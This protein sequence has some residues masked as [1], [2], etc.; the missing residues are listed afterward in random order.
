V[1]FCL[2]HGTHLDAPAHCIP[3]G[4]TIDAYP[5]ARFHLPASVVDCAGR[6]GIGTDYL[7]S[8]AVSPGE[9]V[10][11][12]SAF[13]VKPDFDPNF[14]Y[15]DEAVAGW[16]VEQG[17]TLVGIDSPSIERFGDLSLSVHHILLGNDILILEQLALEPVPPGRYLLSCPPLAFPGAEAGPCR[18]LLSPC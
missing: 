7:A 9:A 16:L 4:K 17:I 18:A 1:A 13:S 8:L 11:F 15:I 12:R 6:I 3:G 10:L 2:H 14:P 5:P